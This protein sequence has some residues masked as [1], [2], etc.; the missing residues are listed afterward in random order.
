M[1]R[2]AMAIA[3]LTRLPVPVPKDAGPREVARSMLVFPLVGGVMGAAVA[4]IGLLL[5]RALPPLVAAALAT[6]LGTLATGALHLD[7]LADSADGLGGGRDAEH[8]LRIMRDHAV[9]TYGAAA[10][11]L[12]LLV[13]VSA[14]A[15][16]L[17]EA[18]APVWL[19]L[20]G[21][22]SRW[23]MVPL[24]HMPRARQDGLGSSVA[25]HVGPWELAGATVFA[26]APAIALG[27][28][29]GLL[30]ILAVGVLGA[31]WAT[32]CWRRIG[33]MTGDTL[34]A[35]SELAEALVLVLG[36]GMG[37]R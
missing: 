15:A 3:I 6:S 11:C 12:V 34:G 20:A 19:P 23:I 1:N 9:G 16:L 27:G 24:A 10:V 31:A 28:L 29:R 36:A 33:G 13:K 4:G 30:A 7:G 21:A 37:V 35:S 2:L 14:T 8:A 17:G 25:A 5:A 18:G 26:C 32:A 22:L